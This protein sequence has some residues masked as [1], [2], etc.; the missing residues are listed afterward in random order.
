MAKATSKA[1]AEMRHAI[2]RA[3]ERYDLDLTEDSYLKLCRQVQDGKGQ[4]L[5]RQTN[6]L[7]V[8]R[9]TADRESR[10][11]KEAVTA[12]VVYDKLRHRIVT[13]LP[14]EAVDAWGVAIPVEDDVEV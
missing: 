1:V 7:T 11:E 5:G 8:W 13:F 9:I 12:N 14:P 4:F 6:R 3:T 10:F 2:R